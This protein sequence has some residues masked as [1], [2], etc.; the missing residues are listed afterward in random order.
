MKKILVILICLLISFCLFSCEKN[1]ILTIQALEVGGVADSTDG[2]NHKSEYEPWASENIGRFED[3]TAPRD[4][5]I[6]FNKNDVVGK[7]KRSERNRFVN[8][9]IDV[10]EG[11]GFTFSVRSDTKRVISFS[12]MNRESGNLT[13]AECRKLADKFVSAYLDINSCNVE[14]NPASDWYNYFYRR[15]I[16]DINTCELISISVSTSGEICYFENQMIGEFEK[17]DISI[18][19][20]ENRVLQL[21]SGEAMKVLDDKVN[22]IYT[23]YVSYETDDGTVVILDNGEIGVLYKVV[24]NYEEEYSDSTISYGSLT[25]IILK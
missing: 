8:Y 20:I 6:T 10:Y 2:G 25:Y 16:T 12:Y 5:S 13:E 24:A 18:K 19:Q 23:G 22:S 3:K 14:V 21:K 9:S 1:S 17:L 4:F 11:D 15:T 7:Y